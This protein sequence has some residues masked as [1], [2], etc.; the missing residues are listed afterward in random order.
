MGTL[1]VDNIKQQSSQGSGTITIGAS[2]ETVSFASGVTGTNY[3]AFEAY[4][5]SSQN[6][7]DAAETK[8]QFDTERFDTNSMYDASTNYRFTPTIAGK[9]VVYTQLG[10]DSSGGAE[11]TRADV[12]IYKN[13]SQYVRN[14]TNIATS[15]Q[16]MCNAEATIDFNGS[17]DYVEIYGYIDVSSGTPFIRAGTIESRFGAYRI[18]T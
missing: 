1:F 2:G 8:V 10:C 12:M 11:I 6:L 17:S 7:S 14:R 9:Y 4:V 13:G 18:G 3:P 5:S 16:I 15:T